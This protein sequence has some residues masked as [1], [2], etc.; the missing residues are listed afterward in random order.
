[1]KLQWVNLAQLRLIFE[2][3]AKKTH[4]AALHDHPAELKANRGVME[5]HLGTSEAHLYVTKAHPG[6]AVGS[7]WSL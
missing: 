3:K 4:P 2:Y 1:L 6:G 5:A 7:F